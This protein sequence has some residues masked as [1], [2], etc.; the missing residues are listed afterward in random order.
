MSKV[1]S[2]KASAHTNTFE[3][4]AKADVGPWA[5]EPVRAI[6]PTVKELFVLS[7]FERLAFR[8]VRQMNQGGWK[9]FWTWCQKT[10]GAGWIHLSTY[11]I[12]NVYG[13]EHIEAASRERPILLVANHRSFLTCMP[14]RPCS[15][16]KRN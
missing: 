3:Q 7:W 2:P 13:L 9:R 15:F 12:M 8:L 11:N 4:D 10:L 14:S 5:L 16:D 1:E 6:Q